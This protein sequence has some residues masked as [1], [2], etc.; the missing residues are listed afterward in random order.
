MVNKPDIKD[1]EILV[2]QAEQYAGKL[3]EVIVID[4]EHLPSSDLKAV[5][6]IGTTVRMRLFRSSDNPEIIERFKGTLKNNQRI[7]RPFK[8]VA[9]LANF[10][11]GWKVHYNYFQPNKLLKGKTPAEESGIHY[12][13]KNWAELVRTGRL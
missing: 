8:Y 2:A 6:G 9:T 4:K 5:T 10:I 13:A 7:I 11:E 12:T 3:P 1:I